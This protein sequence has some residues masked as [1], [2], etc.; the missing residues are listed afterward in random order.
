MCIRNFV[1]NGKKKIMQGSHST[2]KTW[3]NDSRFS[4]HGNMEFENYE[5]D[6]GKMTGNLE[7]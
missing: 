4:S 5:I 6:H 3:E 2:W 7:K 1:V